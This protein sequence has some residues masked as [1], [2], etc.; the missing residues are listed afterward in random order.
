MLWI[1]WVL[2]KDAGDMLQP[3]FVA[4]NTFIPSGSWRQQEQQYATATAVVKL[5]R[6]A[7]RDT[8]V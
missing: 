7:K 5:S 1:W 4:F 8:E 6:Y 2:W 3:L